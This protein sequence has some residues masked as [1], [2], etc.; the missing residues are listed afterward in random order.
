MEV[1]LLFS[2][3]TQSRTVATAKTVLS[4]Q[5]LYQTN[6]KM[7][8][9]QFHI[10]LYYTL[11][12]VT[13]QPL[14]LRPVFLVEPSNSQLTPSWLGTLLIRSGDVETNPG[15]GPP[16]STTKT[17]KWPC[18]ICA[19]SAQWN[20]IQ[21][22]K[23]TCRKW[24]HIKCAQVDLKEITWYN[25]NGTQHP[26]WSCA[27]CQNPTTSP[28]SSSPKPQHQK[29]AHNKGPTRAVRLQKKP[30]NK[31]NGYERKKKRK[32]RSSKDSLPS[33]PVK[34][35]Q[36]NI[37]GL[38]SKEV[39]LKKMIEDHQPEIVIL[40]ETNLEK[41]I[42][43][44]P[45]T[46]YNVER[47]DRENTRSKDTKDSG[48]NHGGVLTLIKE[49]INYTRV[50]KANLIHSKDTITE[51][52]GIN[53]AF[54]DETLKVVN[55]YIPV[56]NNS[57]KGDDRT[58]NFAP[59]HLPHTRNTIIG[60]DLNAHAFWDIHQP[61][62]KRGK[63]IEEWLDE[64]KMT[65]LNT[66]E[67]TKLL[68][69]SVPDV[70]ICHETLFDK[71]KWSIIKDVHLSDHLP[72]LIEAD[73]QRPEPHRKPARWSYEKANWDSWRTKTEEEI[74]PGPYKDG[75]NAA[76]KELKLNILNA[77]K[78][79]IPKGSR[80]DVD[81]WWCDEAQAVKD[82]LID[83]VKKYNRGEIDQESLASS[84]RDAQEKFNRLKSDSW[85]KFATEELN[86][87][88]S[89][90]KV[91]SVIRKLDGR[92]T[93]QHPGTPLSQGTRTVRTDQA[94][95][96]TFIKE[97]AKVSN[98]PITKDEKREMFKE[99][100][101]AKQQHNLR[102]TQPTQE[103]P[104]TEA[105]LLR[106]ICQMRSKKAA[107][108]DEIGNEML[109]NLGENGKA[110]LLS[111]FNSSLRDK[112][113]PVDWKKATIIPIPKPGKDTSQ[114]GAFRP[115]SL[116]CCTSKLMERLIKDRLVYGLES[117]GKLSPNQAGLRFLHSTEDQVLRISQ[118]V[119]NGLNSTPMKRTMMTLIDF[120]RAFDTVW[121]R[122]LY[123]KL[124]DLDVPEYLILWIKAFLS[125]RIAQVMYGSAHSR[126]RSMVNG[127]PQGSV[128]S[129]ILF[130]C[131]I[132]DICDDM[133]VEVSLFAD[134]LA[135][136]ATHHDLGQCEA[137]LQHALNVLETWTKKWKLQLNTD[138]CETTLFTT[139][140]HESKYIPHL[141]LSD[142]LIKFNAT[143]KFLGVT[144]DRSLSFG[145]H[146]NQLKRKMK[147]RAQVLQALRG[148][149]WGLSKRDMRQVYLT[150]IRSAGEYCT[151]A[152]GPS[153]SKTQ[154]EQLEI[155]QRASARV[156]TN[157]TKTTP[158]DSLLLEAGLQPFEI[159][160]KELAA[161]AMEK[162]LRLP[163]SNPRREV[164]R[165][166]PVVTR[167]KRGNWAKTSNE[168]ISACGLKDMK[169]EEFVN[170]SCLPPWESIQNIT[171]NTQMNSPVSKK[172][173][174]TKQKAVALSTITDT[175]TDVDIYTDG[176]TTDCK[177]GGSSG[178][179]QIHSSK[180]TIDLKAPA[181]KLA[182][183]YKT[184]IKALKISMEELDKLLT[185]G[186]MKAKEQVT[187]YTDSM[188]SIQRLERCHSHHEKDLN[189]IQLCLKSLQ[190]KNIGPITL[191]WIP[192]H[193]GVDGNER[194]D[195]LAKEACLL[196]QSDT[197]VDYASAK[198]LI[199]LHCQ[200]E[201]LQKAKPKFPQAKQRKIG[202]ES[203]L[204]R[205]ERTILSRMRTGG[206]TPE[207]G[208]YKK[209]ITSGKEAD[210]QKSDECPRCKQ[211]ETLQHY[212]VECPYLDQHR[213]RIFQTLDPFN[214]LWDDPLKIAFFLRSTNFLDQ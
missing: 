60:G 101:A 134:D 176:S 210:Q 201:W 183:S 142:N 108:H 43:W 26:D 174:P 145:T 199:R 55:L 213:S 202:D 71:I 24:T 94:K 103:I 17:T 206:H 203:G 2:V 90:S 97:Y 88:T 185:S 37:N 18:P 171:Y 207:L 144:F 212:L 158:K 119:S 5:T 157:C 162:S 160:S 64:E 192:G 126:Y 53:A 66:G 21:C 74:G 113:T 12:Y 179:I 114:V 92:S 112:I 93:R 61:Q 77:A 154:M 84:R 46:G 57:N 111:L 98:I 173:P 182:C 130:I 194:A 3:Q 197:E 89:P 131:F 163:T 151:A 33:L 41:D 180:K 167:L 73:I 214:L 187:I 16:A 59:K 52:I 58:D 165:T 184:E 195:Q 45:P 56:V 30:R 147:K 122:G 137:K 120:S 20:S 166:A 172:D 211:P 117:S 153:L 1:R 149:D 116:T 123:K 95:A 209:L 139:D 127:L 49:D 47:L 79:F 70:T 63:D 27:G 168:I 135:M 13:N 200:Q 62:N 14:P 54:K 80:K 129:P 48:R 118:Q 133:G 141:T 36:W 204:S 35:I 188:S 15:P 115:I 159:R 193:C 68:N 106:S 65:L 155:A 32:S 31:R 9:Y 85:R 6:Q 91:F 23:S 109:M 198:S 190:E 150:Y 186:E 10:T 110:A 99:T 72:I 156:I 38:R 105:E 51:A 189:D 205:S 40:Q 25:R 100:K 28:A 170:V 125:D 19:R 124:Y 29:P 178:H 44:K 50:K 102:Q 22:K 140:T 86:A 161:R 34:I 169:R 148:K 96:E 196:D 39:I 11:L 82:Q 138:K 191:Q 107:G 181:G 67:T 208:W 132:N 42:S 87:T 8:L 143:P 104:L 128:L 78:E 177:N 4:N 136:W 81:V 152:W 7:L 146:I 75:A 175:T 164:A 69:K 83:E 76:W 121:K